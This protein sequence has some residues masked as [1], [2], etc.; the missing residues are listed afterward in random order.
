MEVSAGQLRGCHRTPRQADNHLPRLDVCLARSTMYTCFCKVSPHNRRQDPL[1]ILEVEQRS[2]V[3][4][5][6]EEVGMY[7]CSG[8][9]E[10]LCTGLAS[11]SVARQQYSATQ[12]PHSLVVQIS[13]P[14]RP[15]QRS[16]RHHPTIQHT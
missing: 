12:R 15:S 2:Q 6:S 9:M 16:Q 7:E 1:G 5:S 11:K 3:Q 13:T 4:V 10:A 8:M 14:Q